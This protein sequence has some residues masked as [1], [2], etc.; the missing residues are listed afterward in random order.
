MRL[1]LSSAL[2]L[3]PFLC[4]LGCTAVLGIEDTTL[5][6]EDAGPP[7]A[8]QDYGC[9]GKAP[10]TPSEAT[11][12]ITVSVTDLNK[13]PLEGITVKVCTRFDTQCLAAES[14][15]TGKD[16]SVAIPQPT[17]ASG[18][19]GSLEIAGEESPGKPFL[20]VRW[21]FPN[22]LVADL[23]LPVLMIGED[24]FKAIA[25]GQVT[26]DPAAGQ[27]T[28]AIADCQGQPS[29]G[30]TYAVSGLGDKSVETYS[31]SSAFVVKDAESATDKSG[32]AI[33]F[34]VPPG[35]VTVTTTNQAK[36]QV[37]SFGLTIQAGKISTV[38]L[39]PN[40]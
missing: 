34:N 2:A 20:P 3:A 19:D 40:L 12:T 8:G 17:G 32:Q 14:F 35:N 26:F 13:K 16:G 23:A 30:V 7:P 21:F 4:S 37:A 11:I 6:T 24:I 29:S 18:F 1:P 10:P 36:E 5:A 38:I 15:Q 22:P 33:V 25:P 31:K 39:Q 28:L 27:L 9:V